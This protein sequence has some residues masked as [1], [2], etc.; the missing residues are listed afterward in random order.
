MC[1]LST[2]PTLHRPTLKCLD[3]Y[4]GKHRVT[5][6]QTHTHLYMY[7]P[8]ERLEHSNQFIFAMSISSLVWAITSSLQYSL[9]KWGRLARLAGF[10]WLALLLSVFSISTCLKGFVRTDL[11]H[12]EC[13]E[14]CQCSRN[15][16]Y[17][18]WKMYSF[19]IAIV[20][21]Y[22]K[23]S[24][25]RQHK[26]VTLHFR[27]SELWHGSQWAKVKV[28]DMCSLLE[29]LLESPV[30][31]LTFFSPRDHRIPWCMAPFLH[32]QNQQS[33]SS[34]PFSI[35]TLLSNFSGRGSL[36]FKDS[37]DYTGR[38][39]I[40]QDNLSITLILPAKSP[41]LCKI[42]T[43]TLS[44]FRA[45]TSLGGMALLCLHSGGIIDYK[46]GWKMCIL[47]TWT[48]P[49]FLSMHSSI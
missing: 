11:I 40:I 8:E 9:V 3:S 16:T 18:H 34:E 17:H 12:V 23:L 1:V 42:N 37:C 43:V 27:R 49:M 6:T 4:T 7:L 13:L 15:I 28:L 24:C 5:Q 32:L 38:I 44:M 30:P 20:T 35:I 14:Q 29:G 22:H 45:W 21:N 10:E 36:L 33:R 48:I 31:R 41:L 39:W 19:L 26:L 47:I 25:L 2:N 46:S